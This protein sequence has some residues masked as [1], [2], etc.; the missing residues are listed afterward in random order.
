MSWYAKDALK[1][2]VQFD[3]TNWTDVSTYVDTSR[4]MQI[5][6]GR[7]DETGDP[8]SP[9]TW[10]VVLV[11]D[12][13]RF[14]PE[15]AASPYYPY[16][17][18]D[19]AI[20]L[21]ML[22]N[23][24]YYKRFYGTVQSWSVELLSALANESRCT[25]TVTDVFGAFPQYTL[26]QAADEAVRE[27]SGTVMHLPLRDTGTPILSLVGAPAITATDPTTGGFGAGA[28]PLAIEEGSDPHPSFTS[29]SGG[30]Q[31]AVSSI[32]ITSG[33]THWR[34]R[35]ILFSAPTAGCTMIRFGGIS[36]KLDFQWST[37]LGFVCA[38]M[39]SSGLPTT[40]PIVVELGNPGGSTLYTRWADASGT[41][42]SVNTPTGFT[43]TAPT[44]MTINPVL[45]GGSVWSIGHVV[46]MTGAPDST[47]LGDYAKTI[48][49]PRVPVTMSAVSMLQGFSQ[50]PTISGTTLGSTSLPLL[51]GRDASDALGAMAVGM[52]AR[53][54]DNF[55]GTLTWVDFAPSSMP[56]T[57]P[58]YRV[59]PSVTWE[60]S[61]VGWYSDVTVTWPDGTNYTSTRTDGRRA[62][63]GI[64]GVHASRSQDRS[65]ADWLVNSPMKARL[66]KLSFD[67]ATLPAAEQETL[68]GIQVGDRVE[69][70]SLPSAIMPAS[71]ILIVEGVEEQIGD[72]VWMITLTTSPDV[73]SRLFIL[74]DPV[75]GVLDAGYL[76]AP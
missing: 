70:T 69:I 33:E 46:E 24:T 1:V 6:R 52:G 41:V 16:V 26:R 22:A 51:E 48:L 8:L 11:N 40:Y 66:S 55:D 57:L 61:D 76:L 64:E 21:S 36:G 13:G 27:L 75:Q 45:S 65:M 17:V 43:Y 9:G 28:A 60:T 44:R 29:G 10:S 71:A 53:I 67:L 7:D 25:V 5:N 34:V 38:L 73:Y 50:G 14:S 35:F 74:D 3:G 56:I 23:G 19:V 4:T 20:R 54:V 18:E 63:L 15:L 58:A 62:S 30:L 68:V 47:A 2:E 12:D 31:I 72:G 37:S 32:P 59:E 42:T 39:A 49:G